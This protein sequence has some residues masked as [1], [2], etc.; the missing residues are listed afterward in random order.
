MFFSFLA[1]TFT[2]G[3]LDQSTKY[4]RQTGSHPDI[5]G[6]D[7][8]DPGQPAA[9]T[10]TLCCHGEDGEE[11]EGDPGWYGVDVDEEGDPGEDDDE[12]GGDVHLDE[13]VLQQADE[14]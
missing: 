1:N 6:F 7:V 3:V 5:Y 13:V 8:A 11:A 9:D 12:C 14:P 10:G 2:I 4:E